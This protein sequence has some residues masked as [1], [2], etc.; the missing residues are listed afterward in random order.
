MVRAKSCSEYVVHNERRFDV[1]D[2]ERFDCI[3]LVR[4]FS[5][6]VVKLP[7]EVPLLSQARSLKQVLAGEV[8]GV[9]LGHSRSPLGWFLTL[10]HTFTGTMTLGFRAKSPCWKTLP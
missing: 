7:I 6:T 2:Q 9:W 10:E 8:H 1:V 4:N 5:D 3:R